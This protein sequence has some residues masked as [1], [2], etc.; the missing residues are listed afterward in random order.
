MIKVGINI[1]W[2]DVKC[3]FLIVVIN[4]LYLSVVV[5]LIKVGVDVN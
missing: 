1:N 4:G 3:I 5:E 2:S